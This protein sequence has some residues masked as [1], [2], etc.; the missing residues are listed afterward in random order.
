MTVDYGNRESPA[1]GADRR[2]RDCGLC[3]KLNRVYRLP[4]LASGTGLPRLRRCQRERRW[5]S[6]IHICIYRQCFYIRRKGDRSRL[7]KHGR[8]VEIALEATE[9]YEYQQQGL[10]VWERAQG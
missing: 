2:C 4:P 3:G 8:K 10:E 5:F 1:L 9:R 6:P 7:C